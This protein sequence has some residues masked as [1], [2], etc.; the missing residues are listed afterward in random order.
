MRVFLIMLG[1]QQL[2]IQ[3]SDSRGHATSILFCKQILL[4][5]R[6]VYITLLT[7][8]YI[9]VPYCST[10]SSSATIPSLMLFNQLGQP[11]GSTTFR[12]IR[13]PPSTPIHSFSRLFLNKGIT[14]WVPIPITLSHTVMLDT[15]QVSPDSITGAQPE[16]VQQQT[17]GPKARKPQT[18]VV[19]IPNRNPWQAA[20]FPRQWVESVDWNPNH[21]HQEVSCFCIQCPG[22]STWISKLIWHQ[23]LYLT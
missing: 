7:S 4:I 11:L 5:A 15:F 9:W 20:D 13:L 16:N 14:T 12:W 8:V 1:C 19:N 18:S 17:N 23:M 3:R 22:V 2:L 6:S 10:I 21:L